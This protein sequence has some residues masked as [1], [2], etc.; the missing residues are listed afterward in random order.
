MHIELKL[1]KLNVLEKLNVM[2]SLTVTFC[3]DLEWINKQRQSVV[4]FDILL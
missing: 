1:S 2:I 4:V 3:G